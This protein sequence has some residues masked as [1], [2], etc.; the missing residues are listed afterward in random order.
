[1]IAAAADTIR[2]LAVPQP[3]A[4]ATLFQHQEQASVGQEV[5]RAEAVEGANRGN[6][7]AAGAA[8]I[9][10]RGIDETVAQHPAAGRQRRLDPPLDMVGPRR[11]KQQGFRRRGPAFLA[12]AQ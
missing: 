4:V 8:L 2:C 5:A 6:A 1:V 10:K 11:G 9:G 7:E 3:G 12:S